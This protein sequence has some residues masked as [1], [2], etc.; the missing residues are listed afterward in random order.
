MS[1]TLV[2]YPARITSYQVTIARGMADI[3]LMGIEQGGSKPQP[4]GHMTFG[5]PDPIG[6]DADFTTRGGFLQMDRPLEMLSAVLVL[7]HHEKHLVLDGDGRLSTP[8]EH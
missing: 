4:V 5:D 3:H 1:A 2:E 8:G 7:L 6:K